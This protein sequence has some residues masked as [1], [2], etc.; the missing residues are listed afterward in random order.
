MASCLAMSI[1]TTDERLPREVMEAESTEAKKRV[2]EGIEI[3]YLRGTI[4]EITGYPE[5]Y[6]FL[7]E[8][9]KE[10]VLP[11]AVGILSAHLYDKLK[12]KKDV[13]LKIEGI[14][15]LIDRGEIKRVLIEK[16]EKT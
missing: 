4:H 2:S 7:I 13:K 5:T 16:L 8:I 15:I 10:V 14:D 3:E 1:V 9:G 12:S 6:D 11:T